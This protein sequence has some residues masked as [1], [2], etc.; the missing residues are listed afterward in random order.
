MK[1]GENQLIKTKKRFFSLFALLCILTIHADVSR[2]LKA[3]EVPS[4]I[5]MINHNLKVVINPEGHFFSAEDTV[6]VSARS[7]PELRFRLHKGL[8]PSSPTKGV[9]IERESGFE[10]DRNFEIY[11]V[12]LHR[13]VNTF[14]L[15]YSGVINHP[16]EQYGKEQARGISQTAGIIS[17][18][19]VYLSGSSFWYPVFGDKLVTF[20]LRLELPSG[21]DAVSQGERSHH[22]KDKSGTRVQWNSPAPQEEIYVVAAKFHEYSQPAGRIA[23]MVFLRTAD[24]GLAEKYLEAA[25]RYV[26]MYDKLIGPYPYKK[27]ALVENFWETGFGMPSFTL[28]GPNVIR[29]PFIVDT[30]YPHEILH[31]WWG[32]S[33][34]PDYEK[35]NWSEGLTAYLSDYLL[36]EQKGEGAEYRRSALQKY[37]NYVTG[38]RDFPIAEFR[39]RHSS[40]SEAIGYGKSL[41]FFHMLRHELG[42][43]VFIEGLRYF[44]SKNRFKYASFDDVRLCFERVSG[45]NLEKEFDQWIT[46]PGAPELKIKG[47]R[48]ESRGTDYI[49][50]ASIE[51]IQRGPTYRLSIPIA[52]TL[53]GRDRA[54]HTVA[55]MEKREI[56]I[57]VPLTSRPLR[58][59]IDPEFDV[60][61]RLGRDE[62]PPAI[63][64]ALGA[65]EILVVL[66]SSAGSR[67]LQ[68][69]RD[70]AGSLKNSGP[71][72]VRTISDTE[73]SALPSD[74]PVAVIGRENRFFGDIVSAVSIY[75]TV[76]DQ[77]KIRIGKT[78]IPFENHSLALTAR[79][80]ENKY[81]VLMFV[82]SGNP[83]ALPGLGRKLPHYN[84]F[85][86]LVFEGAEPTNIIKG[87]W[88]STDSP[89]TVYIPSSDGKVLR[90]E[91]GKL[92]QRKPLISP[93]AGSSAKQ[94]L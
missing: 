39:S 14:L 64:K 71:V 31:N 51:Q 35:G 3:E 63:S 27:F 24:K 32:N 26:F 66:P 62:V 70:F 94:T 8:G 33:V 44:Y 84:S 36:S 30:S 89:M 40:S 65:R 61:R 55:N 59:D 49:L 47:V 20:N 15:K 77:E 29:F 67:L 86:Y 74:R 17:E 72:E 19:G 48:V 73:I 5:D 28:L 93:Q 52:I 43:G 46:K 9:R 81:A 57:K 18:E 42:D 85:S 34:F 60:F 38:R 50:S 45:K 78:E 16:I 87:R 80:T 56:N 75:G 13:G 83:E 23:A 12:N 53:E 10:Q 90:P 54:Y 58:I 76:I 1:S 21:W 6:T 4:Q 91:M 7:L 41:M 88:P 25:G 82:A 22:T 37:T 2:S 69:Y 92:E 11:K 79:N 68:A